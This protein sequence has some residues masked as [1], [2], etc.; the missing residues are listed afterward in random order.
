MQTH[1]KEETIQTAVAEGEDGG[2]CRQNKTKKNVSGKKLIFHCHTVC[3]QV[4]DVPPWAGKPQKADAKI[5]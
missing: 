2:T 5:F 1:G 4:D 3:R